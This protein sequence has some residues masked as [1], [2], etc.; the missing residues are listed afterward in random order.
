[1]AKRVSLK[2]KGADLFF[3][4]PP[5]PLPA[6]AAPASEQTELVDPALPDS[7]APST[8]LDAADQMGR[9][10]EQLADRASE[11]T[12]K[13][14]AAAVRAGR[15]GPSPARPCAHASSPARAR[16]GARR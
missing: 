5:P 8:D 1:M 2:G 12:G 11:P 13:R 16:A 3:G 15:V 10:A 7:T 6:D 9:T 14:A 4:T